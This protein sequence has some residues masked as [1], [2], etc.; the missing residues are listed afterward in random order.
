MDTPVHEA[1]TK[2]SILECRREQVGI[3]KARNSAR[4]VENQV[5]TRSTLSLEHV[6]SP[7]GL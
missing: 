7:N 6:L 3:K 5:P 2:R 1:E 4:I